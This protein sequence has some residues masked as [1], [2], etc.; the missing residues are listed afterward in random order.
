MDPQTALYDACDAIHDGDNARAH[1]CLTALADWIA[2]GGFL[3]QVTIPKENPF[4]RVVARA[5]SER[6]P[7]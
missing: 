2:R 3:P 4:V 7:A 5:R 1:E 6:T